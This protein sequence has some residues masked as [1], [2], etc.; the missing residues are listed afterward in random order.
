MKTKSASSN[1][2]LD[3]SSWIFSLA[4]TYALIR[5]IGFGTTPLSQIPLFLFNKAL[6]L[7]SVTIV[8]LSFAIG[9][10]ARMNSA[11]FNPW[12]RDR[13]LFGLVGYGMA[14]VHTMITLMLFTP[15]NYPKFFDSTTQQING[16]GQLA[17]LFGVLAL[18]VT[19]LLAITSINPIRQSMGVAQW[20]K[21]HQ[22]GV[23]SLALLAGH[24]VFMGFAGWMKPETWLG[25]LPPITLIAIVP[26]LGVALLRELSARGVLAMEWRKSPQVEA[27]AVIELTTR[28]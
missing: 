25:G 18:A 22:F 4:M 2:V 19:T 23:S 24:I 26:V 15:A 1:R 7:S 16:T 6:A 8:A 17:V 21:L 10:L 27:A 5:Y 20:R 28:Y 11:R 9:P 3:V 13:K 14:A 12:M